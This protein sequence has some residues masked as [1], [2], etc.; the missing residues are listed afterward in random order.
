MCPTLSSRLV[1]VALSGITGEDSCNDVGV[2]AAGRGYG[3]GDGGGEL[4]IGALCTLARE[5]EKKK[6]FPHTA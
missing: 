5:R 3:V 1:G 2:V 6:I 4:D